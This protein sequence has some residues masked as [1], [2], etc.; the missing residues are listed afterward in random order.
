MGFPLVDLV[1]FWINTAATSVQPL[2]E[3]QHSNS[4]YRKQ[5]LS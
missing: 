3:T 4:V 5:Q 2:E 1:F